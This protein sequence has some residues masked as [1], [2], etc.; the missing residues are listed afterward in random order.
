MIGYTTLGTND[1]AK[2]T[3]FYDALLGELG[4]TRQMELERVVMWGTG[5]GSPMLGVIKPFDGRPAAVMGRCWWQIP[6][7]T[8]SSSGYHVLPLCNSSRCLDNPSP[9]T[10]K[11]HWALSAAHTLTMC[12]GRAAHP[13]PNGTCARRYSPRRT[14]G[15]T[16]SS[17][18]L[19]SSASEVASMFSKC[20][21]PAR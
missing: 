8:P 18:S 6:Q 4:A 1:L 19:M 14:S 2:A 21:F 20:G 11:V 10:M 3:A 15:P 9:A 7:P 17:G 12:A 13:P 16:G 5:G